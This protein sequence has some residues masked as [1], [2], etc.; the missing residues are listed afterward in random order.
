[1]H[2]TDETTPQPDA[3]A[4]GP[5]SDRSPG[6]AGRPNPAMLGARLARIHAQAE[7]APAPDEDEQA[8][9]ALQ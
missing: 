1:M 8:A 5:R 3:H 2:R 6:T 9:P 7:Q 4:S